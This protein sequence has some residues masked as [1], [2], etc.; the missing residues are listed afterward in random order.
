MALEPLDLLLSQH[1]EKKVTIQLL[2]KAFRDY[3]NEAPRESD[4]FLVGLD[5]TGTQAKDLFDDFLVYV[6]QCDDLY[7]GEG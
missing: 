4:D 3:V 1:G 5:V 6:T 2:A 7:L